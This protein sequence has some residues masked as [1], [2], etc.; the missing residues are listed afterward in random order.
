[1]STERTPTAS[2]TGA[3]DDTSSTGAKT[4]S[5]TFTELDDDKSNSSNTHTTT[6]IDTAS[7]N[8]STSPS[9]GQSHDQ[10]LTNGRP[11]RE[12][13]LELLMNAHEPRWKVTCERPGY[14]TVITPKKGPA[15]RNVTTAPETARDSAPGTASNTQTSTNAS[16]E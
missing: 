13:L 1:M 5:D 15:E 8:L 3:L 7:D 10:S 16:R 9:I 12:T 2:L 11:S 4:N 6:M 14:F